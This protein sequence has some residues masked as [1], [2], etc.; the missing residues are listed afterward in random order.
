[1]ARASLPLRA[2]RS[3]GFRLGFALQTG[4]GQRLSVKGFL[5]TAVSRDGGALRWYLREATSVAFAPLSPP[6]RTATESSLDEHARAFRVSM[7]ASSSFPPM[8]LCRQ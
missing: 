1:M 4:A 5:P 2:V 7:T 8:I 3:D 6:G